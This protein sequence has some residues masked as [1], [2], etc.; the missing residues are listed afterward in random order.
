[1]CV[2]LVKF[3]AVWSQPQW[4]CF[5]CATFGVC[6]SDYSETPYAPGTGILSHSQFV[7]ISLCVHAE[8][9]E[10]VRRYRLIWHRGG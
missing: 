6:R 3:I 10:E 7:S 4:F 2:V 9:R 8:H 5:V 1:M